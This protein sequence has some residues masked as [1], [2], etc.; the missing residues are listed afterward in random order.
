MGVHRARDP[1]HPHFMLALQT[2][3]HPWGDFLRR[4]G[5]WVFS[6]NPLAPSTGSCLR[7]FAAV[8]ARR[9]WSES[10]SLLPVPCGLVLSSPSSQ[11]LCSSSPSLGL[12]SHLL[13]RDQQSVVQTAP[14]LPKAPPA[15][16]SPLSVNLSVTPALS[17]DTPWDWRVLLPEGWGIQQNR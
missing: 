7:V 2:P 11:L 17:R 16:G 12:P 1:V 14:S 8:D 3:G 10:R 4:V 5:S 6:A 13:P 15:W 9:L